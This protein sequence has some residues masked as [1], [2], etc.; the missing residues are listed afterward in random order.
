[1]SELVNEFLDD[2]MAAEMEPEVDEEIWMRFC[3]SG[4][5]DEGQSLEKYDERYRDLVRK[6]LGRHN[7]KA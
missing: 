2:M 3:E 4:A 7:G 5:Y 6:Q 1:M